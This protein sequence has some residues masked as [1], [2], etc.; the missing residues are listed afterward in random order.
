M[1]RPRLA[2]AAGVV[3]L[4][5]ILACLPAIQIIPVRAVAARPAALV[6]LPIRHLDP[7]P[8]TLPAWEVLPPP[9][10]LRVVPV[11]RTLVRVPILMYHYVRTPPDPNLDRLGWGLSTSP[12]DFVAQMD[13]LDRNGYHPVTLTELREYLAGLRTLPDR[14]VVLT[15]D[16]GYEDFYASAFPVLQA[17]HFRA[18]SYV[19]SGFIGRKVY[20]S[21][22]QVRELDRAGIEIAAHTVDHVDLTRI[23]QAQLDFEVAGSRQS[24]EAI[25]GH[26]VLDFCYPSGQFNARVVAAVQQA[27]FQSATTTQPG[28]VHSLG[29][30]F[31]WSRVR[32]SGGESMASFI[33]GVSEYESGTMPVSITPLPIQI[34]RVYPLLFSGPRPGLE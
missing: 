18:V 33:Q 3:A 11:G 2:G 31:S 27:G 4:A 14:P 10:S 9:V 12:A 5:A 20:L 1:S 22:D 34:P 30:R 23:G 24:L 7:L 16:D 19:V 17:H 29:D 32:V 25:V 8:P 6:A 26:P 21:A 28:A 15:F 13:W